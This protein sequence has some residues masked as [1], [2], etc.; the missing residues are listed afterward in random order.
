M[1]P[2]VLIIVDDLAAQTKIEEAA[3]ALGTPFER[4]LTAQDALRKAKAAPP[5]AIFL[6]C[7]SERLKPL[8]LLRRLKEADHPARTS[9]VVGIVAHNQTELQAKVHDLGCDFIYPRSAFLAQVGSILRQ[10]VTGK[11]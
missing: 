8:A 2:H 6:D 10:L 5:L 9:P 3:R 4:A 7:S 1:A 11:T